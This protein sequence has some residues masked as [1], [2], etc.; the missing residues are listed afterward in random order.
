MR[1]VRALMLGIALIA[2]MVSCGGYI[3]LGEIR[4]PAA[5]TG[6][7]IEFIVEPGEATTNIATRLR[8]AELIRQ[9]VVFTLLTR[10]RGLDGKLQAGRYILS[11]TMTMSTI[12]TTLQTGKAEEAQF[13]IPEGLRIEEIATIV[14]QTGAVSAD[15]FLKVARDGERFREQYFLLSDLPRGGTLEG[16]L[17]PDTY[18][19]AEGASAEDIVSAMLDRFT[20]QYATIERD[21]R[22]PNVTV[23]QLLTMASIVQREAALPS[24][25]PTISAV[26]W[27][28]LKPEN[29]SI[30]S[31]G[32]LGADPT[33]Q[34]A[35]GYSA[36]ESTWW[37]KTISA[38]DLKIDSPYNTRLYAGLPP[39]PIASAGID[40][41]RA[42]AQPD[43]NAPYLFFVA[44]CA[45]D[46][47][48]KFATTLEEF[49]VY[50]SEYLACQ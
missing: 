24:E 11:P 22:V 23:H 32:Q 21:V 34:Y 7:P 13:T 20:D 33:V 5:T 16:Y 42:A 29:A 46:G 12:M 39:G 44:S 36:A 19:V 26:F 15:T 18:R 30:V 31:G 3:I 43:D 6:D 17:F 41:L 10:L 9:P 4:A 38:A 37:R 50:E 2:L 35:L 27:N 14:E 49:N 25:M 8:S 1:H 40:A 45:K 48:H 47:S 28:R